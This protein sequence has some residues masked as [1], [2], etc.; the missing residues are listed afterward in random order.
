MVAISAISKAAAM[1]VALA[2]SVTASVN[3]IVDGG[4][5]I[6]QDFSGDQNSRC[7]DLNGQGTSD[8][9]P[10][11]TYPCVS[12]APNQQ[13]QSIFISWLNSVY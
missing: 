1:A 5:Y 9:T 3:T 8:F 11:T 2:A 7:L 4:I 12:G 6:M 10:I 13:V